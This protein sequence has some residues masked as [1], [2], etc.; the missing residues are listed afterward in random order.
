MDYFLLDSFASDNGAGFK[1]DTTG[2]SLIR[3]SHFYSNEV[4]IDINIGS[5]A[6]RIFEN[7]F[8][9]ALS[10]RI[11]TMNP[12]ET[13]AL[14]GNISEGACSLTANDGNAT[15]DS[16]SNVFRTQGAVTMLSGNRGHVLSAVSVND[17]FV[18]TAAHY[19]KSGS[20][21]VS[22]PQMQMSTETRT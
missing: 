8:E 22:S 1:A 5:Q 17:A 6:L 14:A 15:V 20:V 9:D 7:Y 4:D 2:G 21:S 3:G 10:L 13:V 16:S 18:S 11:Q 19:N 12:G